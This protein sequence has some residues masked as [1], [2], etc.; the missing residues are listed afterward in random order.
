MTSDND[1]TLTYDDDDSSC[2]DPDADSDEDDD[3]DDRE[4]EKKL[5]S[6]TIV[7]GDILNAKEQ[8]ICH[9]CNCT[10]VNAKGLAKTIFRRFPWSRVYH[11]DRS[12]WLGEI[13][14]SQSPLKSTPSV[15][16]MF[17]QDK[18]GGYNGSP[19]VKHS[20]RML[21]KGCLEKIAQVPGIKSLAFPKG[22]GCGLAGRDWDAYLALIT[23]F[24]M[25]YGLHVRIYCK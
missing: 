19:Y 11:K 8:Y 22:I 16:H 7:R 13:R 18:P 23:T 12:S 9:Q 2:S 1:D 6:I 21:F 25:K 24:A 15:I 10:S 17:A 3:L 5:G 4:E 20:R 14:I